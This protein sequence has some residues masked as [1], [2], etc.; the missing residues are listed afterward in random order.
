[1]KQQSAEIVRAKLGKRY[2]AALDNPEVVLSARQRLRIRRTFD[3]NAAVR[4]LPLAV[5]G[6]LLAVAVWC[7][8]LFVMPVPPISAVALMVLCTGFG[9]AVAFAN[10]LRRLEDDLSRRRM[11]RVGR[12]IE[13]LIDT[14]TRT[15]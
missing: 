10:P 6:V 2:L 8:L 5:Y 11:V 12:E 13:R 15:R 3:A 7:S 9:F 4:H 14:R 1:M